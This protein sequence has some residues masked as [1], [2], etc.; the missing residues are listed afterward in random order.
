MAEESV[1][2]DEIE[3]EVA[4]VEEEVEVEKE[5]P[6]RSNAFFAQKRI[7]EKQGKEIEKLKTEKDDEETDLTPKA[8]SAIRKELAPVLDQMKKNA[9][10]LDVERHL[11]R[12][13]EDAKYEKAIRR[14]MQEWGNVPVEEIAKTLKFGRD[15][16]EREQKKKVAVEKSKGAKLS[17][18]SNREEESSLPTE[19][20]HAEIYK[21]MK[22]GEQL[23]LETGKWE[24]AVSR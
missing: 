22:K 7:I 1:K 17:G 18:S 3:E 9:D 10:D 5:V 8:Q 19:V 21:R 23:N 4:V 6:V 24:R 13:P 15:N 12:H 11:A 14:R 2:D 16:E 20:D